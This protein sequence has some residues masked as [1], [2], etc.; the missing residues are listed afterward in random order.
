MMSIAK[1]VKR[2]V[3]ASASSVRGLMFASL[4]VKMNGKRVL[5][6]SKV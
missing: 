6:C 4:L 5:R 1:D 3:A 2:I